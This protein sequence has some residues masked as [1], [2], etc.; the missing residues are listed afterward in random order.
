MNFTPLVFFA[1]D[2]VSPN[3]ICQKVSMLS[4]AVRL[5]GF[6]VYA[7]F[8]SVSRPFRDRRYVGQFRLLL[9]IS[10]SFLSLT[11][12]YS[13]RLAE[14]HVHAAFPSGTKKAN[15]NI[16]K[17]KTA[18]GCLISAVFTFV[19]RNNTGLRSA[20]L[21]IFRAGQGH[22]SAYSRLCISFRGEDP[23]MRVC[24]RIFRISDRLYPKNRVRTEKPRC[25]CR[26]NPPAGTVFSLF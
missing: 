13:A 23:G 17:L 21:R 6:A 16:R 7:G 2:Y 11:A 20:F 1:Q 12:L 8:P 9:Y 15:I 18:S 19:L 22:R 25:V 24:F 10:V 4:A 5:R 14:K 3:R 26:H